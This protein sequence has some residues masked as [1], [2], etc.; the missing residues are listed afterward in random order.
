METGKVIAA[1]RTDKE[2][3]DAA[4]SK[5]NIIFYL[6]PNILSLEQKVKFA[7]TKG[8]KVFIHLDLAEGIGKDKSG[9]LYAKSL[10]VDGIISTRSSIIKSAHEEKLFTVQR[11]FTMDSKSISVAVESIKSSKADMVEIMPGVI[12]KTIKNLKENISVPVIAG[13]LIES[14]AEAEIA[15]SA[16]AK[17]IST[18]NR[19]LW[20]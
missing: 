9:I 7:H 5:V 18:G 3:L 12:G 8:K 2:F 19:D 15:F 10:G 4:E 14:P 20:G 6:A 13:G 11:F 17:A 1:V 16:G